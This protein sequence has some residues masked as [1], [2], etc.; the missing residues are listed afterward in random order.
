MSGSKEIVL[1]GRFAVRTALASGGF[2]AVFVADDLQM[3]GQV[4]VKMLLPE[5]FG[6]P[7]EVKRFEREAEV[8]QHLQHPSTVRVIEVGD[9]E[10]QPGLKTPW[11]AFELVRGLQLLEVLDA[12]GSLAMAEAAHVTLGVLGALAEAHAKGV[13]HRDIKPGNIMIE[14]PRSAWQPPVTDRGVAG[15]LGVPP[16]SDPVWHDLRPLRPKILDFGYAKARVLDN[17]TLT[18]LTDAGSTAGTI[19]FMS[20]EQIECRS[21]IDARSDLYGLAMVFYYMVAGE[22]PFISHDVARIVRGHL[23]EAPPPLPAPW[24][25][26]PIAEVFERAAAKSPGARFT[27]AQEMA[28]ALHVASERPIDAVRERSR[29][30]L[31]ARIMARDRD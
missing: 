7:E 25:D 29:S 4:A 11:I 19:P 12:R 23:E 9:V 1:G 26:H 14:A 5:S 3:G 13:I 18:T 16:P 24:T 17:R 22:P 8:C 27:G 21:D 2:G 10:V 30:G 20:P 28:W 15:K 31:L 6:R